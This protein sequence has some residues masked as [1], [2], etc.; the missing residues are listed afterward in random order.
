MVAWLESYEEEEV[1]VESGVGGGS[2]SGARI[3]RTAARLDTPLPPLESPCPERSFRSLDVPIWCSL[4]AD[5]STSLLLHH[6]L[7]TVD[8][9]GQGLTGLSI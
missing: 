1:C 8:I 5:A 4:A 3:S 6:H 7:H 9:P 2:R